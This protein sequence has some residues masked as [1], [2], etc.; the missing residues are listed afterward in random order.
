MY[1]KTYPLFSAC[2]R[3]VICLR[4]SMSEYLDKSARVTRG[5]GAAELS[6]SD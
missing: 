4:V 6:N 5:F 1:G 3:R 2:F